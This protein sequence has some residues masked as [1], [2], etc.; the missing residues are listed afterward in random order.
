[1]AKRDNRTLAER[2]ADAARSDALQM[3]H[4][5]E[6]VKRVESIRARLCDTP[7]DAVRLSAEAVTRMVS[8]ASTNPNAKPLRYGREGMPNTWKDYVAGLQ[9]GYV[10]DGDTVMGYCT[11]CQEPFPISE[12]KRLVIGCIVQWTEDVC[13]WDRDINEYVEEQRKRVRPATYAG[14]GCL[15]CYLAYTKI[16]TETRTY[17]LRVRYRYRNAPRNQRPQILYA[18]DNNHAAEAL[19]ERAGFNGGIELVDCSPIPERRGFLDVRERIVRET[20]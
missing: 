18:R 19:M 1:M 10:T 11:H 15:T 6:V 2:R 3:A 4:A 20:I 7:S 5:I 8:A 12:G 16:D 13:A 17:R 9:R 14:I